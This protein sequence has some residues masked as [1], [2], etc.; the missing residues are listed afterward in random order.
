M[1]QSQMKAVNPIP[2]SVSDFMSDIVRRCGKEHANWAQDFTAG[3]ANTL[4]T[5]VRRQGDETFLLTGDIPAMWLRDSAA[6]VRPYLVIARHDPDLADIIAGLVRR[7]IRDILIDPY[8]NAFNEKGDGACWNHDLTEMGPWIWERKYEVDSLCY[9]I[10]LAWLLWR[11]TGMTSQFDSDFRQAAGRILDV[12]DLERDHARNSHYRFS[13]VTERSLDTLANNGMGPQCAVTGMTWSGFRASDDACTYS[14]LVPDNMF[15]VVV[16]GY[17]ERIF[18]EITPDATLA[19]RARKLHASISAGLRNH[20][21]TV[22]RDGSQIWAYEVD[23]LGHATIMDDGNVP[24]LISAP[25]LG[26]CREDD[27]T[28]LNTRRVLL[29][30]ENP[31]YYS[32]K[33]VSGIGSSH[34]PDGYVW[35]IALSMQGLTSRSQEEKER[36]L[37]TLVSI[38]AGTHLMHEGVNVND[39]TQ[40]T[41]PWFSWSNML[42]SELVMDVLGIH[43]RQ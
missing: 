41:R 38:D 29:S 17:M 9:P 26:F 2:E 30:K 43:V 33:C 21:L 20:A 40:F 42:F 12:W 11:N 3:F 18:T 27:P 19:D 8:A 34:T 15:A 10:Q 37:D 24:N 6:Q 23:G 5:T 32:G 22:S 36:L 13:R 14:Y 1:A 28:Y 4:E 31:F 39:P 16:L 7:Q 35:P 25:Y